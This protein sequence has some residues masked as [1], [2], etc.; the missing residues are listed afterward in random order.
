VVKVRFE[1]G[2]EAF[3]DHFVWESDIPAL[4][5]YLNANKNELFNTP[6]YNDPDFEEAKA[7]I[8]EM[9]GEII[10]H[11]E[12]EPPDTERIYNAKRYS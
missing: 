2:R 4:S 11:D 7:V 10:H 12:Q 9:G 6:A 3:I 8:A 5:R 1:D